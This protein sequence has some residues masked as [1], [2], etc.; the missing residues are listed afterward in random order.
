MD[1]CAAFSTHNFKALIP[2]G[3]GPLRL[4]RLITA[5][6]IVFSCSW[7]LTSFASAW[8]IPFASTIASPDVFDSWNVSLSEDLELLDNE[9]QQD[10]LGPV[11]DLHSW[12]S[13]PLWQRDQGCQ[14]QPVAMRNRAPASRPSS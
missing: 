10:E 4:Q 14:R 11:L 5:S 1:D 12:P 9:L 13:R 8:T 6:S 3:D 7:S 2:A